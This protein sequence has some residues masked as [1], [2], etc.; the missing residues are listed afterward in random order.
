MSFLR[1]LSTPSS[2]RCERCLA[3]KNHGRKGEEGKIDSFVVPSTPILFP[4]TSS[5][6]RSPSSVI[7]LSRSLA[8]APSLLS[9]LYLPN[10]PLFLLV[11]SK[12]LVSLGWVSRFLGLPE[13]LRTSCLMGSP[14]MT[15]PSPSPPFAAAKL[16]LQRTTPL[17]RVQH[18]SYFLAR[19]RT[20]ESASRAAGPPWLTRVQ[21]F[22]A[23]L[24]DLP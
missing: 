3:L 23:P 17:T 9:V 4:Q 2:G 5:S 16:L 10:F 21:S 20:S 13:T 18:H 1:T 15:S 22:K 14:E 6:V 7:V 11:A 8:F 12:S 24:S 19:L